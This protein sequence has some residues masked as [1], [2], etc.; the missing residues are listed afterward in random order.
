MLCN[1]CSRSSPKSVVA[2]ER[3]LEAIKRRMY[4]H[5]LHYILYKNYKHSTVSSLGQR[6]EFSSPSTFV[7]HLEKPVVLAVRTSHL[8]D[9]SVRLLLCYRC[10]GCDGD[11]CGRLTGGS[12]KYKELMFSSNIVTSGTEIHLQI[13]DDSIPFLNFD[14]PI[15]PA[16]VPAT[17]AGLG[18]AVA[19]EGDVVPLA[20][21]ALLRLLGVGGKRAECARLRVV[22][23]VRERRLWIGGS[24][25]LAM[26]PL[27]VG[28]DDNLP[29]RCLCSMT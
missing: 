11:G 24:G 1:F 23:A 16:D 2:L 12:C 6:L 27:A 5:Y 14:P 28:D 13:A 19:A 29:L 3:V 10:L 20:P 18:V 4:V 25:L 8:N 9:Q 15:S 17:D 26:L 22:A 7:Q 21:L